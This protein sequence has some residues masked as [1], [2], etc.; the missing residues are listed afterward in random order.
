LAS[1]ANL[2]VELAPTARVN[3]VCPGPVQTAMLE[4]YLAE[5]LGA[6]PSEDTLTTMRVEAGRVPLR[7]IADP[8]EVATTVAHLA[9]DASAVTGAIV[10]VDL[11]YTAR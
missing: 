3:C 10:P 8:S 4:Q 11:G 2:A 6:S 5:Y 7:R 9:L 1:P